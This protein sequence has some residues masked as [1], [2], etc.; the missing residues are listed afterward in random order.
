MENGHIPVGLAS[1]VP[2]E[3]R[4]QTRRRHHN[5]QRGRVQGTDRS[6]RWGRDSA[7]AHRC[8]WDANGATAVEGSLVDFHR[9]ETPLPHDPEMLALVFVPV[10]GKRVFTQKPA[11]R[12]LGG[13]SHNRRR[14]K[15]TE[16]SS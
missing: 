10:N 2:E 6:R 16:P 3:L 15:A 5:A 4:M 9:T 11:D 14:L 12:C 7:G 1:S 8:R 13:F